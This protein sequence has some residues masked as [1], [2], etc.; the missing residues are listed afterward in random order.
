[1]TV[2]AVGPPVK[3]GGNGWNTGSKILAAGGII[4]F[5]ILD[6]IRS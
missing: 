4:L 5:W 6:C 3:T 1:M 2:I